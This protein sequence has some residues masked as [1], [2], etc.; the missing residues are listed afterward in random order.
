M[1]KI[2]GRL[3]TAVLPKMKV[4]ATNMQAHIH[5]AMNGS[6]HPQEAWEW[7]RFL[8]TPFYQTMFCKIG[9]WLPS[10]KALMTPEGLKAWMN[11]EVHPEGY[12][13]IVTKYVPE[14]GHVQYM[15]PGWPKTI[16]IMTPAW[17]QVRLGQSQVSEVVPA[18][19][20]EANKILT[21]E[22]QS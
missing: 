21:E 4:P 16:P 2:K 8:S 11:P 1:Y 7:V 18:A 17:D 19:M 22:A 12:D 13:L 6:K 10:Q 5:S 15:P 9:L 14:Y 3:G 20:E